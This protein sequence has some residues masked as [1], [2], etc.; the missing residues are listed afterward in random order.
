M[1]IIITLLLIVAIFAAIKKP[2]KIEFHVKHEV[3]P[4]PVELQNLE[5]QINNAHEETKQRMEI[6]E[7]IQNAMEVFNDGNR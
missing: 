5:N 7:A 2:I 3:V 4:S 1:D 6:A